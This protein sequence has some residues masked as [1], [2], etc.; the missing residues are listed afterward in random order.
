MDLL[1]LKGEYEEVKY[2]YSSYLKEVVRTCEYLIE[3]ENIKLAFPI[4]NRVKELDSIFEKNESGRYRI[5]SSI[6]ELNDLVGIRIVVLF[7]ES[8][9]KI[10]NLLKSTFNCIKEK[11]FDIGVDRF[12]YSSTHLILKLSEDWNIPQLQIHKEKVFEAQVRTLSE[13]IWAETSHSLFYKGEENIPKD[14]SRDLYRLSAV[15][16]IVDEK[17]QGLKEKVTSYV[18]TIEK[19][20]YND[21]LIL[22]LNPFTLRRVLLKYFPDIVKKMS[23]KDFKL[24]NRKIEKDFDIQQVRLLND[25]LQKKYKFFEGKNIENLKEFLFKIIKR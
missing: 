1:E 14:I 25:I 2:E 20:N 10:I 19:I 7:Q 23:E 8:K 15:L 17:I 24:L 22:D 16:E 21:L 4:S 5:K 13:H 9:S 6:T 3:K 12:S 11:E 18:E